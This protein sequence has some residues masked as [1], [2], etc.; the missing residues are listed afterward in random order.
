MMRVAPWRGVRWTRLGG[1]T[2]V[3]LTN[4]TISLGVLFLP[5]CWEVK[6]R[7]TQGTCDAARAETAT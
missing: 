4:R 1:P 5:S 2:A 3:R 6:A 7:K